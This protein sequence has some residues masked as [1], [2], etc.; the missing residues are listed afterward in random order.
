MSQ[1]DLT[2]MAMRLMQMG[3][4]HAAGQTAGGAAPGFMP[5]MQG[6]QQPSGFGAPGQYIAQMLQG[7]ALGAQPAS[8]L[9]AELMRRQGYGM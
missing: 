3:Q 7:R 6:P 8:N 5:P 4:P 2:N 1:N 9:W